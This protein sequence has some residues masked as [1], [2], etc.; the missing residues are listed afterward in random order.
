MQWLLGLFNTP[1]GK[2][3][4]YW[5]GSKLWSAAMDWAVK[6]YREIKQAIINKKNVKKYSEAVNDQE[7]SN[8]EVMQDGENLLNG[9]KP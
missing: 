4:L 6:K 9:R 2:K 7:K 3:I 5:L 8:D 1:L